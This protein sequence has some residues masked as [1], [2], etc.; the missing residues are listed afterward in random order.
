MF[1]PSAPSRDA[2]PIHRP[3]RLVAV[4]SLAAVSIGG[5]G[6][7]AVAGTPGSQLWE[8]R[9]DGRGSKDQTQRA[10]SSRAPTE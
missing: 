3:A 10:T 4:L 5:L 1:E 7:V 2:R 6:D 9:Y 8:A